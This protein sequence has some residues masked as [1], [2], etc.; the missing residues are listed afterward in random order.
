MIDVNHLCPNCMK[1]FSTE[2][3]TCPYCG[4]QKGKAPHNSRALPFF[5]ILGGR[6]LLGEPIGSGGFGITYIAMDLLEEKRVAIKE[7]FPQ[8]LANRE[9]DNV[10]ALPGEDGRAF[11]EALRSFQ[12]E[13]DLLSRFTGIQGIV[14]YRDFVRENGTSYLVMDYVEG[15]NL[16]KYMRQ[17]GETFSQERAQK[18]MHPILLAVDAMHQKNVLHRDISPENLILK[19]DGTLTLIDFGAAREYDLEE[20]ENLTVILKHGYAPE[21]QYH[22]GSHQGP[23]TDVYACCAVLY[24]IISGIL[25]QD[26]AHREVKDQVF[27]LDEIEGVEVTDTFARVIEKGMNISASERYSSIQMLIAELYPQPQKESVVIE[28]TPKETPASRPEPK[29]EK[30]KPEKTTVPMKPAEKPDPETIP[31]DAS[32]D[33]KNHYWGLLAGIIGGLALCIISSV[34]VFK[35]SSKNIPSTAK[36]DTENG[37]VWLMTDCICISDDSTDYY[38]QYNYNEYGCYDKLVTCNVSPHNFLQNWGGGYGISDEY[39]KISLEFSYEYD[40]YDRVTSARQLGGEE[41]FHCNYTYWDT[42]GTISRTHYGIGFTDIDEQGRLTHIEGFTDDRAIECLMIDCDY[43][44]DDSATS[45]TRLYLLESSDESIKGFIQSYAGEFE[46]YGVAYDKSEDGKVLS[47][48]LTETPNDG[49]SE[50]YAEKI[51]NVDNAVNYFTK[52]P[53]TSPRWLWQAKTMPSDFGDGNHVID[54]YG[55]VISYTSEYDVEYYRFAEYE[56]KN[57]I[58]TPTGRISKPTD[59]NIGGLKRSIEISL[60]IDLTSEDQDTEESSIFED[61]Y[62][63]EDLNGMIWGK[64]GYIYDEDYPEEIALSYKEYFDSA[65]SSYSAFYDDESALSAL[66]SGDIDFFVIKATSERVLSNGFDLEKY[67]DLYFVLP[68]NTWY[69]EDHETFYTLIGTDMEDCQTISYYMDLIGGYSNGSVWSSVL[70][71]HLLGEDD[72]IF[73]ISESDMLKCHIYEQYLNYWANNT[74]GSWQIISK[75]DNRILAEN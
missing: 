53:V 19:P 2:T 23:W 40:D 31:S 17:T 45:T 62:S 61:T 44:T 51:E 60:E 33:R 57:G 35:N 38:Y 29:S 50:I 14:S 65:Q 41:E 26:A 47:Y 20:E 48:E 22:T 72:A 6:Y 11:R 8:S 73:Q 34:F 49:P 27:P 66:T 32:V 18:L 42:T 54:D 70:S 7:F 59:I 4:Y 46:I 56:I 36:G 74:Q 67:P 3:D 75:E 63:P 25:P 5:S 68:T 9:G 52:F 69:T 1:I 12:K 21:E 55:N 24:Q 58:Y 37:T 10:A 43:H 64:I 39:G 13:A 16:K 30:S 71:L 28:P 15:V